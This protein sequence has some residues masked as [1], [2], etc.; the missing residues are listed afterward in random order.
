[1][2]TRRTVSAGIGPPRPVTL[3]GQRWFRCRQCRPRGLGL[4]D[5]GHYEEC[6]GA[7]TPLGVAFRLSPG[8]APADRVW[9]A[10]YEHD[11]YFGK[12]K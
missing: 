5:P 6:N 9:P 2:S 11:D 3:R 12:P 1:M 4:A 10:F 8:T 7:Q